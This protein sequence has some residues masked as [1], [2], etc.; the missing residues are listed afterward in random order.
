M[1]HEYRLPSLS[2]P[3]PKTPKGKNI[4]AN[5]S[6]AICRIF[7][8]PTSI[9][10]RVLSHSWGPQSIAT[11]EPELLSALQSIQV[12]HFA[13]ESSSCSANQFNSL[14][15]LHGLQL[16]KLNSSQ[17]TSTSKVITFNLSSSLPSE[18]DVHS[19]SII[20][21]FETQSQHKSSDT[22]SVLLSMAPG[23]LNSMNEA[24][25]N[26]ELRRL[27]P[28][29][30]YVVDWATDMNLG[31]GNCDNDP[32]TRKSGDGYT[33]GNE[34]GISQKIKFPFDLG[35]ESPDDWT[36]SMPCDSLP[37]ST[38]PAEMSSSNSTE[39]YYAELDV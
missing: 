19:S 18:K 38:P 15:C 17:D 23:I 39:K 20:L 14:Q 6:W 1:M 10:Q 3:R 22:K 36:S 2:D 21:P 4:P 11:T 9:S 30:G 34:C 16:Q 27:E 5:D 35:V 24:R 12:S 25:P 13:L 32:Y 28:S 33:S 8:K 29:N 26:T 31:T 37:L 7:K